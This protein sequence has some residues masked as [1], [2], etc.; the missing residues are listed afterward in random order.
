[1]SEFEHV[2]EIDAP[3]DNG[4]DALT[5]PTN[6]DTALPQNTSAMSREDIEARTRMYEARQAAAEAEVRRLQQLKLSEREHDKTARKEQLRKIPLKGKLMIAIVAVAAVV[7]C[8]IVI[9]GLIVPSLQPAPENRYISTADLEKAVNISKLSTIDYAYKGIAEKHGWFG[10]VDY[11]IKYKARI[12]VSFD[13]GQIRF[14]ENDAEKQFIAILPPP[15][16]DEPVIDES[17]LDYLPESAQ[18]SFSEVLAICQTDA[19]NEVATNTQIDS[20]AYDSLKKAVS[21]LTEPLLPDGY[22]I[23]W[24]LASAEGESDKGQSLD[25]SA[26]EN[27]GSKEQ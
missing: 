15:T 9:G 14:E 25:N 24:E 20:F 21:A 22:C 5:N 7:A 3:N 23:N 19:A 10:W 17:E 4:L 16:K 27:E 26:N 13:M 2:G 11:R 8:F 12:R 1:M 6:T 18:A